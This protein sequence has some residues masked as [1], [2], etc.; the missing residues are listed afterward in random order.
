MGAS[1]RKEKLLGS[2]S[3][4]GS[5]VAFA[6]DVVLPEGPATAPK[7]VAVPGD[8]LSH[9]QLQPGKRLLVKFSDDPQW[10]HE[11]VLL[12]EVWS[13]EW[14]ILTADDDEYSEVLADWI[15]VHDISGKEKYPTGLRGGVVRFS[16]AMSDDELLRRILQARRLAYGVRRNYPGRSAPEELVSWF[17]WTGARQPLSVE[18]V[19]DKVRRRFTSKTTPVAPP[20]LPG[21]RLADS[22]EKALKLDDGCVWMVVRSS[23]RSIF[24]VGMSV[25]SP[26]NIRCVGEFGLFTDAGGYAVV[27]ERVSSELVPNF[28]RGLRE[29]IVGL[30]PLE[31]DAG[32]G[33]DLRERLGLVAEASPP[34]PDKQGEH[35]ILDETSDDVRTLAI[36]YDDQ[37]EI[38]K[39]WRLVA[40]EST[41]CSAYGD[42]PFESEAIS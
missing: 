26:K 13:G 38:F 11:R 8:S 12:Y 10:W 2:R 20:R 1:G 30:D 5:L 42:W 37:G 39:E 23:S 15:E 36:D 7:G 28:V 34:Q 6:G 40:A 16:E 22:P 31:G 25:D 35:F 29:Q 17:S 33:R 24:S 32:A 3:A 19:V 9:S 21:P 14:M 4:C 18:S 41:D 27:V